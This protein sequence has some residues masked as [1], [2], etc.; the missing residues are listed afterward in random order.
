MDPDETRNRAETA[1]Y[2]GQ[3]R[4]MRAAMIAQ[5]RAAGREAALDGDGWRV[6]PPPAFY[7]DPDA[8]LLFQDPEW[9][10]SRQAIPGYSE[11]AA[12]GTEL[13]LRW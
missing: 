12:G 7:S 8:G 4:A 1:G 13:N 11:D 2:L 10:A 9:A 3:T 6:Y 5:L